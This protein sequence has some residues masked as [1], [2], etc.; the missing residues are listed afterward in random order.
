MQNRMQYY[1]RN[2][3][4]LQ[5]VLGDIGGL[6]N[7]IFILAETLNYMVCHYVILIDTED[8]LISLE[9][10]Q[11]NKKKMSKLPI[12]YKRYDKTRYNFPPKRKYSTTQIDIYD[13]INSPQ[14]SS[15]CQRLVNNGIDDWK[16]NSVN[17][18]E[19]NQKEI[20]NIDS[21]DKKVYFR[22]KQKKKIGYSGKLVHYYNRKNKID[23][24]LII[25]TYKNTDNIFSKEKN[26]NHKS[27]SLKNK[28]SNKK[29][30][31]TWFK[32]IWYILHCGKNNPK[33]SYFYDFRIKLIS[34]E[35]IIQNY[36]DMNK[37]LKITKVNDQKSKDIS[38]D[39]YEFN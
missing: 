29:N 30:G 37:L 27:D 5:D 6:G 23:N 35:N 1:E 4:R 21:K 16:K 18:N 11:N 3:Q 19:K 7:I 12:I 20:F 10:K 33:I 14:A 32:Y 8:L 17:N 31:F 34:E 39:L 24:N 2:Y 13:N 38:N 36:F 22:K 28:E 26:N 15:N 25:E 9:E